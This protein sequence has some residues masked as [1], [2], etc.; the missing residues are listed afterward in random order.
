[1]IILNK[2]DV[3]FLFFI[4]YVDKVWT[5][6]TIGIRKRFGAIGRVRGDLTIA[7]RHPSRS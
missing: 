4:A 5:M 3:V 1:M 6:E 7:S 2:F